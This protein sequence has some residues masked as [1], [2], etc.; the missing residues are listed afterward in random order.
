MKRVLMTD[1][2]ILSATENRCLNCGNDSP[3][4]CTEPMPAAEVYA[5][6]R[7]RQA[8]AAGQRY[9][10]HCDCI[11][12]HVQMISDPSGRWLLADDSASSIVQQM[13]EAARIAEATVV[14]AA[15]KWWEGRVARDQAERDLCVA[16]SALERRG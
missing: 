7:E 9:E 5:R 13:P 4:S 3:C 10:P 14:E 8:A 11:N 6:H 12:G 2:S 1:H 16:L 15:L